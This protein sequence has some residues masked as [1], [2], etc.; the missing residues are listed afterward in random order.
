LQIACAA[1]A[2]LAAHAQV[3]CTARGVA[4]HTETTK[5]WRARTRTARTR[6]G[7]V[8]G[9]EPGCTVTGMSGT[10][11]GMIGALNRDSRAG[12]RRS[13]RSAWR[14]RARRRR[15]SQ[16]AH[17]SCATRASRLARPAQT[18]PCLQ[19]SPPAAGTGWRY[20]E[21]AC[22]TRPQ[23]RSHTHACLHTLAR[24]LASPH[25]RTRIDM[26]MQPLAQAH[27]HLRR[28]SA[29]RL[30]VSW[31]LS[32]SSGTCRISCAH[33]LRVST[34][35]DSLKAALARQRRRWWWRRWTQRL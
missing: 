6:E 10:L 3:Y 33:L 18:R 8:R 20:R 31:R 34:P 29:S 22:K 28:R 2:C 13:M 14:C 35:P 9:G 15:S 24:T 30:S 11:T 4:G 21:P 7:T 32:G 5:R 26:H 16:T 19:H 25:A 12:P 17:V 23:A 27:M 1:R